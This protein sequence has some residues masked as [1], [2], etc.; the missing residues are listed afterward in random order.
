VVPFFF[1][2]PNRQISK[3]I[4][5]RNVVRNFIKPQPP[6]ATL[7]YWSQF[8]AY[9]VLTI[10]AHGGRKLIRY[11]GMIRVAASF[12]VPTIGQIDVTKKAFPHYLFYMCAVLV[13]EIITGLDCHKYG[14][15]A[16]IVHDACQ[17]SSIGGVVWK[18][19]VPCQD[20]GCVEC[21]R[22]MNSIA[23][24]GENSMG[25]IPSLSLHSYNQRY[26]KS[27]CTSR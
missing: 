20:F 2:S 4:D 27:Y 11:Q 12:A 22:R 24:F 10:R 15:E 1:F 13:F 9:H 3:L 14:I 6:K 21:N 16:F 23:L 17:H 8:W 26:L 19:L 18:S 5:N 7:T 25:H